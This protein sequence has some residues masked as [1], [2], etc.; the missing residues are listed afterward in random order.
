MCVFLY[1]YVRTYVHVCVCEVSVVGCISD[2]QPGGLSFAT[3]SV[4]RALSRQPSVLKC[5]VRKLN[6]PTHFLKKSKATQDYINCVVQ[7]TL[8]SQLNL[9]CW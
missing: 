9:C 7:V 8:V 6:E 3:P 1:E 2:L 5:Y 4:D